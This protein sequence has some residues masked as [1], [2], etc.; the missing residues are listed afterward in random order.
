MCQLL[1]H[2]LL[3]LAFIDIIYIS[4]VHSK[5]INITGPDNE[6][7]SYSH[8]SASF[9]QSIFYGPTTELDT[10]WS[11]ATK[12]RPS[13]N[14]T[15]QQT[16]LALYQLNPDMFENRNIHKLRFGSTIRIPSLE[17]IRDVSNQEATRIIAL[18]KEIHKNYV[19]SLRITPK[20]NSTIKDIPRDIVFNNAEEKKVDIPYE[21]EEKREVKEKIPIN[22]FQLQGS[23]LSL[24]EKNHQ[25]GLIVSDLQDEINLLKHELS[26]KL[27]TLLHEKYNNFIES[28]GKSKLSLYEL[29]PNIWFLVALATIPGLSIGLI[30]IA[31]I[32][33][34][35]KK[36][37]EISEEQYIGN[38][39]KDSSID[40]N[41]N[42]EQLEV[43]K[44]SNKSKE[45]NNFKNAEESK[46]ELEEEPKINPEEESN[47]EL[48]EEPKI[49]PE[50]ESKLEL[51]EEPKI[52]P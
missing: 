14:V 4:T 44:I 39:S 24:E 15:I 25:M 21:E 29:F 5:S 7:E 22:L 13:S 47:L 23:F 45:E 35:L 12:V 31:F 19:K 49:N 51:E 42:D 1:K 16:V 10:L 52:N 17:Q 33:R 41:M 11:I 32:N 20:I 34:N 8:S 50:E 26:E 18:H 46:L 3:L 37:K 6:A 30:T 43:R 40:D 38:I 36:K 28:G 2:V 48:E 27:E 9:S